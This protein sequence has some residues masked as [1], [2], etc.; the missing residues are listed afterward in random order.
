MFSRILLL[1]LLVFIGLLTPTP[2]TR[3]DETMVA[4]EKLISS[5]LISALTSAY[6][7]FKHYKTYTELRNVL[8]IQSIPQSDDPDDLAIAEQAQTILKTLESFPAGTILGMGITSGVLSTILTGSN[9]LIPW[10]IS[11]SFA[12]RAYSPKNL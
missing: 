11:L 9:V 3:A 7:T 2:A 8:L 12:N 1:P 6:V 10:L 5:A 4:T